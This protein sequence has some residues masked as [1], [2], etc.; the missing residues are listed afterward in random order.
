MGTLSLAK[1]ASIV[2]ALCG[3]AV[4][5]SA[6]SQ[7]STGT[8]SSGRPSS[9]KASSGK[10]GAGLSS[11]P[12]DA[13]GPISA[14]LGK[15][16]PGYWVHRS[17]AGFHGE[18]LRQGLV[19]EF[20]REGVE[21]RTHNLRWGLVTRGYGYGDAVHRVKAVAPQAKA[22][23][24]EYRRDGITEWYENGPLG[25]EQ[26]FTLSHRPGKANDQPLTL[27]LGLRG[28]LVAALEPAVWIRKARR[29]K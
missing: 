3:A 25:L 5:S 15:D 17:A 20:T 19:T 6:A 11:L 18:N 22:N 26:G 1:R 4:A 8:S 24:V 27:E 13:Q 9:G 28:D 23:R 12:A 14:A 29:W 16:D 7:S 2:L 21:V 10:G